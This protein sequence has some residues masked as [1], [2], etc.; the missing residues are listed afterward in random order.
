MQ[1]LWTPLCFF[2][3]YS[4]VNMKLQLLESLLLQPFIQYFQSFTI[5]FFEIEALFSADIINLV[6]NERK[7]ENNWNEEL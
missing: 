7:L 4:S 5:C 2:S 1:F 3:P 6:Q